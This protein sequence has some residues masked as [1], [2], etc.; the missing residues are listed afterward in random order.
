MTFESPCPPDDWH[1]WIAG[2]LHRKDAT[3]LWRQVPL[4]AGLLW[5]HIGTSKPAQG[6]EL[7]NPDWPAMVELGNMLMSSTRLTE[8]ERDSLDIWGG[9][10]LLR[11]DDFIEAGGSYYRPADP[12]EPGRD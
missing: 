1:V 11:S 10:G 12:I 5:E 3:G 8:E 7:T 6:R 2:S 4:A 9:I